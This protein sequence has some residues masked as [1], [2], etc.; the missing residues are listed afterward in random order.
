VAG[1][2]KDE[3]LHPLLVIAIFVVV[4]RKDDKPNDKALQDLVAHHARNK[5]PE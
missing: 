3:S 4:I 5:R 2:E 1:K